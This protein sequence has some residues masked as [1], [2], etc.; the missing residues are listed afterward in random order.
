MEDGVRLV[1]NLQGI[2]AADI[3]PGL[4]VEVFFQ[5]VGEHVLPQFRPAQR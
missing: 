4:P 5:Q 3:R 1:S 2:D